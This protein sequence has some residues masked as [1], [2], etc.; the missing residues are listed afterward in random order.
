MCCSILGRRKR[1]W[2]GWLV[3]IDWVCWRGITC[4]DELEER[5]DGE[6]RTRGVLRTW[7]I[8]YKG[9]WSREWRQGN[10]HGSSMG[11]LC[12]GTWELHGMIVCWKWT[13]VVREGRR[14]V[15]SVLSVLW[16][17]TRNLHVVK[18]RRIDEAWVSRLVI[19]SV[20]QDWVRIGVSSAYNAN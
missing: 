3:Y 18:Y 4:S 6:R 9:V 13:G 2:N 16:M 5:R 19:V 7:Y 11:W 1:E 8:G 12:V 15:K 17:L 20:R 14:F 10:E